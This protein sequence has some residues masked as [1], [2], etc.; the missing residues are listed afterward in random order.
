MRVSSVAF[1]TL[2][3]TLALF[4]SN[5]ALAQANPL[6]AR[7]AQY[8]DAVTRDGRA[9]RAPRGD[10]RRVQNNGRSLW[11]CPI[12]RAGGL[13]GAGPGGSGTELRPDRD[14]SGY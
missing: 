9:T 4:G 3:L 10:C 7:A 6:G 14:S 11:E 8:Y 12:G 2:T 5:A 1:L 13:V